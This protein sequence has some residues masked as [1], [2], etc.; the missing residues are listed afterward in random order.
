M[1]NK[2]EE[3][4]LTEKCK[5]PP[6]KVTNPLVTKQVKRDRYPVGFVFKNKAKL[7]YSDPKTLEKTACLAAFKE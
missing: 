4:V 6:E 1:R 3:N 2:E 7:S 5:H